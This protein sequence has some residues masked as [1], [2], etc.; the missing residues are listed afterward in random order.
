DCCAFPSSIR[1]TAARRSFFLSVGWPGVALGLALRLGL[2]LW[3]AANTGFASRR[4]GLVNQ[5]GLS[6]AVG[7]LGKPQIG[8]RQ[9]LE[10]GPKAEID[11]KFGPGV[12][13]RSLNPVD[14]PSGHSRPLC[15]ITRPLLIES[16]TRSRPN[17]SARLPNFRV[18]GRRQ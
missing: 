8:Q 4:A 3:R 10:F 13:V 16:R 14:I 17:R 9:I 11:F 7:L 6:I 5:I 2:S 12:H 15:Q 1:K 18:R